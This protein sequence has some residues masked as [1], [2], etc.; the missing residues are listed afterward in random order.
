MWLADGV[1]IFFKTHDV[2][3][4]RRRDVIPGR[5]LMVDC[6]YKGDKY[7]IVN[8]YTSPTR[9]QKM[10]LFK[11]MKELLSVGYNL[12]LC[13]D[14]NTVTEENDRCSSVSFKLTREGKLLKETCHDTITST[15]SSLLPP[16]QPL[17]SF[18]LLPSL[19]HRAELVSPL[20]CRPFL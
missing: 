7:R 11:R 18:S 15:S 12:I 1:G 17:V 2:E 5:L 3:I 4:I 13:G 6:F 19:T 9:T 10:Q 16:S 14:F 20:S 8:V